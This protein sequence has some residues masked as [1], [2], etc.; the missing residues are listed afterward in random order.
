MYL[1]D[2]NIV[3]DLV[4]VPRGRAASRIG[5]VGEAMVRTSIIVA[6]E[7]RFGACKRDRPH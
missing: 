7:L 2:T 6:A 1:L 3:A 5:E 4:R